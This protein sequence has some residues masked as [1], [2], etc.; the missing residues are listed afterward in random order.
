VA[1][2]P[3]PQVLRNI[4]A[5]TLG[6]KSVNPDAVVHVVW[7]N[8]WYDPATEAEAAK[9]LIDLGADVLTMH[10][11]S[12]L[13]VVQ[14]AEK[15]GIYSVGYHADLHNFAPKGWLTGAMW[16]WGDLYLKI[17]RSVAK[18]T[19]KTEQYR[20]GMESGVV[21]IAPF[22]PAVPFEVQK[23]ALDL[24]KQIAGGSFVVFQGPVSDRDGNERLK[25]GIK[26]DFDWMEKM[27]WFVAGVQ[28]SIPKKN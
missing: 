17:G 25:V 4:N 18:G 27:D 28:G 26:P 11:D 16:D 5:F 1:A 12:P 24:Q 19:W 8:K 15:H 7:T 13:T 22:G 10:Q 21:K 9:G 2:H 20:A 14:T 3:I 6:A 23:E